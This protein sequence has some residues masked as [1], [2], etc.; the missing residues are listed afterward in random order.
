[1]KLKK[2]FQ[3]FTDALNEETKFAEGV[4]SDGT[5]VKWEGELAEGVAVIKVTE[6]G[7]MSLEDFIDKANFE[8][9]EKKSDN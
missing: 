5:V 7:E 6:E 3:A 9:S 1:M 2:A 8:V 4:L